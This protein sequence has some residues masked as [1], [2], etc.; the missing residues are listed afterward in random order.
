MW[1]IKMTYS[2]TIEYINSLSKFGTVLG[3]DNMTVLLKALGS[4]EKKLNII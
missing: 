3:L 1:V 2:E 4:P